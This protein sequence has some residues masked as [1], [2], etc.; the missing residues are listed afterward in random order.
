MTKREGMR[1]GGN[2]LDP[3]RDQHRV[4]GP[5]PL[6]LFGDA[7]VLEV[8]TDVQV[9]DV[10]AGGLEQELDRLE[11]T[12]PNRAEG[13][14]E[15]PVPS[16]VDRPQSLRVRHDPDVMI[17]TAGQRAGAVRF[18]RKQ[19]RVQSRVAKGDQPGEVVRCPL[20]PERRIQLRRQRRVFQLPVVSPDDGLDG[21]EA[22]AD[23]EER[24]QAAAAVGVFAVQAGEPVAGRHRH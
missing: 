21:V 5:E 1:D 22:G 7:T 10:L 11:H 17:V 13:E 20:V 2:T 12:R 9:R 18:Q 3:F 4:G 15:Q 6:E 16:D 23:V 8:R 19:Q 24:D 14:G